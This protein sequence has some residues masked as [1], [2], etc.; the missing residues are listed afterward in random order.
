MKKVILL[1][2][3]FIFHSCGFID[4]FINGPKSWDSR[5]GQ[6]TLKLFKN[7][8]IKAWMSEA[9]EDLSKE[10][11]QKVREE[12]ELFCECAYQ[13][14]MLVYPDPRNMPLSL[15]KQE[16]ETRKIMDECADEFQDSLNQ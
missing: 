9:E 3:I 11:K 8:C 5:S 7:S 12:A 1:A 4:T 6:I 16:E 13:K 10:E 14:L 2:S 15:S